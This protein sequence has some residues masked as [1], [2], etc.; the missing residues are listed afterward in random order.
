MTADV[1]LGEFDRICEAPDAIPR[2]RRFILDLAVRGKLVPQD[3]DD[4]PA[5]ELLKRIEAERRRRVEVGERK[6]R[7]SFEPTD[8]NEMPF[9]LPPGWG[10]ARMGWLAEKLGAGSTPL[11]GKS[12]YQKDGVPFIRS[13]NVYND[14]LR[15]DDVARISRTIHDKMSGTHLAHNDI[16]LNI[17]GASI[18]RSS[19]VPETLEEGNVSQH[20]AIIRLFEP[21]IRCFIHLSLT[22]P[23]YQKAIDDAEVG[24]SREGLSMQRLRQFAIVLPPLAE[25]QRIVAKVGE[26]MALCDQLEAARNAREVYRDKLVSATLHRLGQPAGDAVADR[27]HDRFTLD[28]LAPLT[29]RPEHIKQLRQ[30]ILNLAVRGKLVAQDPRDEPASVQLESC[31]GIRQKTA[32]D[33]RRADPELQ[34]PMASE[35]RWD[36]PI[37]WEWRSLA[38]VVLFI[39]YR[40]QTPTK[41]D[42]GVR[43]I[44]AKN[45]KK[46][47][48]NQQPEEFLSEPHYHAWMTRGLP[49]QGDVL[50]TTEAPM[51]NAAAVRLTERFALAQRVICFRSYG[52]VAPEFLVLQLIAEPFQSILDQTATGLTAKGIKAAKLKRLPLVVPPLA[53]QHRI[54][55]KVDEL[56]ALCDQLEAQL[57]TTEFESRRLLEAALH[58]ALGQAAPSMAQEVDS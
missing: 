34:T 23:L 22:S 32:K 55:A 21:A 52:A 16:L 24:V 28:H 27:G 5:S 31:D 47:F 44:T 10:L 13:Q 6:Q 58:E 53:E 26:L 15:L 7:D 25:Q 43:L 48:I 8:P 18:G 9:G 46:G 49:L 37:S 30:A 1:L 57:V 4:E 38:D 56:M 36:V 42:K 19:L 41:T 3:P 12:V 20:V 35:S 51:G 11:G 29:A 50:F 14:G 40:G 39:D 33:D 45:V 54:V 2:L 17:T